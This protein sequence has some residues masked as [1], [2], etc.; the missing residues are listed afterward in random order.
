MTA[1]NGTRT[2]TATVSVVTGPQII[3]ISAT[4]NQTT[5]TSAALSVALTDD[6][7]ISDIACTWSVLDPK[8]GNVEFAI[9]GTTAAQT[10]TV[11][12][13]AIGSYQLQVTAFDPRGPQV[14][15]AV[16]VQVVS[17]PLNVAVT[18]ALVTLHTDEQATFTAAVRDQFG[19]LMTSP[20]TITWNTNGGTISSAGVFTA[21]ATLGNAFNVSATV[22]GKVGT[23]TAAVT[24]LPRIISVSASPTSVTG[25]STIL[26]VVASASPLNN[27]LRYHWSV[28]GGSYYGVAFSANDSSAASTTTATFSAAGTYTFTVV[29]TDKINQSVSGTVVVTVTQTATQLT[30]SPDYDSVVAHQLDYVRVTVAD[31][32]GASFY[33]LPTITWSTTGGQVNASQYFSSDTTGIFTVTAT[34][35]ALSNSRSITVVGQVL[36]YLE[37]NSSGS[38]IVAPG[39]T[40]PFTLIARD[41]TYYNVLAVPSD[42]IWSVSGGGTISQTGLFTAGNIGGTF[43]VSASTGGVSATSSVTVASVPTIT[44]RPTATPATVTTGT[45]TALS[46]Q[47]SD[48]GGSAGLTY[49]WSYSSG[50]AYV[51]F[52]SNYS[53]TANQTTATFRQAG[54][55]TISVQVT[56]GANLST[57][58]SVQVQVNAA[59]TSL[60]VTPTTIARP[61]S[62]MPVQFTAQGRD[63]FNKPT[64]LLGTLAWST[65]GG[66]T[67]INDGLFTPGLSSGG[68]YTITAA[69]ADNEVIKGTAQIRIANAPV[70]TQTPP[71][72]QT[73]TTNYRDLDAGA[74]DVSGSLPILYSWSQVSGPANGSSFYRYDYNGTSPGGSRAYFS[75][76][77]TYELNVTATN[78][79]GLSTTSPSFTVIV[80]AQ[81]TSI[82]VTPY[83]P[84]VAT[85]LTQQFQAAITDQFSQPFA[86]TVTWSLSSPTAGTISAT[87][88]F[89][90]GSTVGSYKVT[91]TSGTVSGQQFV[92]VV[93]PPSV[94]NIITPLSASPSTV[95]GTTTSLSVSASA[96]G[97]SY[98]GYTWSST[99]PAN[100]SFSG[101]N[102]PTTTATFTAAG[103][104]VITVT[105][106]NGGLIATSSVSVTVMQTPTKLTVSP[107]SFSVD[108]NTNTSFWAREED[109]FKQ[110]MTSPLTWTNSGIGSVNAQ[111]LYTAPATA[112][113][114][115]VSVTDP[116]NGLTA[117][118]QITVTNAAP[119]LGTLTVDED[120]LSTQSSTLTVQATDD[121]GASNLSYA[122]S[123]A[124]SAPGTVTF[125]V[126]GTTAAST[127]VATFS[128]PGSYPITVTVTDLQGK[129]ASKSMDLV[130]RPV[131]APT[132]TPASGTFVQTFLV[133]LSAA[134]H[135]AA[136]DSLWY[137]TAVAG[138]TPADPVPGTVGAI[139]YS[140]P[141]PISTACSVKAV[142]AHGDN[143]GS[144]MISEVASATYVM[145][146]AATG[147]LT[148]QTASSYLLP[149]GST[150]VSPLCVIVAA[151]TTKLRVDIQADGVS[152]PYV[153]ALGENLAYANVPLA[154]GRPTEIT[155]QVRDGAGHGKAT[156]QLITWGA[157]D[158]TGKQS[159]SDHLEIRIGDSVLITATTSNRWTLH[160]GVS[161]K[162]MQVSAGDRMPVTYQ[163]AGFY[164]VTAIAVDGSTL[165]SLHITVIDVPLPT[166]VIAAEVNFTRSQRLSVVPVGQLDQVV[167]VAADSSA[168]GVSMTS[169]TYE[170]VT[171]NLTPLKRGL[172]VLLARLGSATGPIIAWKE[173]D[174]FELK[175]IS[176]LGVLGD[177]KQGNTADLVSRAVIVMSP[178]IPGVSLKNPAST[179]AS[180]QAERPGQIFHDNGNAEWSRAT[181]FLCKIVKDQSSLTWATQSYQGDILVG[182]DPAIT[183]T[184]HRIKSEDIAFVG[185]ELAVWGNEDP[186]KAPFLLHTHDFTILP[187]DNS[188]RLLGGFTQRVSIKPSVTYALSP[189]NSALLPFIYSNMSTKDDGLVPPSGGVISGAEFIMGA[190]YGE[191][192][193]HDLS[194]T[195]KFSSNIYGFQDA[196]GERSAVCSLIG[197]AIVAMYPELRGAISWSGSIDSEEFYSRLIGANLATGWDIRVNGESLFSA[198][199]NDDH[200]FD[201]KLNESGLGIAEIV[202]TGRYGHGP[203]ICPELGANSFTNTMRY[204]FVNP[205]VYRF[206]NEFMVDVV[207]TGIALYEEIVVSGKGAAKK[208]PWMEPLPWNGFRDKNGTFIITDNEYGSADDTRWDDPYYYNPHRGTL[209][210]HRDHAVDMIQQDPNAT[211]N[212][213]GDA[214]DGTVFDQGQENRPYTPHFL[215]NDILDVTVTGTYSRTFRYTSFDYPVGP[216]ALSE[217]ALSVC[218]EHAVVVLSGSSTSNLFFTDTIA[219]YN[220]PVMGPDVQ[221]YYNSRDNFDR[222]L[223]RGW[224]TNYD[225]RFYDSHKAGVGQIL[226]DHNSALISFTG[227]T[228]AALPGAHPAMTKLTKS[229][230]VKSGKP[231]ADFKSGEESKL[232]RNDNRIYYFNAD[233]WLVRIKNV[234]NEELII[235]RNADGIAQNVR[236]SVGRS[237][238]LLSSEF[239]VGGGSGKIPLSTLFAGEKTWTFTY[240]TKRGS[241]TSMEVTNTA[242]NA[243][244]SS[245]AYSVVYDTD[246]DNVK[247]FEVTNMAGTATTIKYPVAD[248]PATTTDESDAWYHVTFPGSVTDDF[249]VA[250]TDYVHRRPDGGMRVKDGNKTFTAK[251]SSAEKIYYR[252]DSANAS[253][254]WWTTK[255]GGSPFYD[256]TTAKLQQQTTYDPLGNLIELIIGD[257]SSTTY[258]KSTYTYSDLTEFA[259]TVDS[260]STIKGANVLLESRQ[261]AVTGVAGVSTADLVTRMTYVTKAGKSFGRVA[262]VT[263]AIGGV[264]EY[265]YTNSGN[266]DTMTD[267]RGKIWTY[268]NHTAFGQPQTTTSPEGRQTTTTYLE[269][270]GLTA[271]VTTASGYVTS[272]EYDAQDRVTSV[273]SPGIATP[274]QIAYGPLGNVVKTT[275]VEN[276][277]FLSDFDALG[278]VTRQTQPGSA[279]IVT[280]YVAASGGGWEITTTQG[281]NYSKVITDAYGRVKEMK[282]PHALVNGSTALVDGV[283]KNTYD[284]VY[285]WLNSTTDERNYE[286]KFTRDILG[287]VIAVEFP[288]GG[289]S[290][291]TT[292]N[293]LGWVLSSTNPDGHTTTT[294]YTAAGQPAQITSPMGGTSQTQY[295]LGGN[296][297]AQQPAIGAATSFEYDD[298]GIQ[299]ATIDVFGQRT[300]R[301]IDDAAKTITVTSAQAPSARMITTLGPKGKPVTINN[302]LNTTT[303]SHYDDGSLN[304]VQ[305]NGRAVVTRQRD[306]AGRTTGVVTPMKLTSNPTAQVTAT[307]GFDATTGLPLTATNAQKLATTPAYAVT[308]EANAVSDNLMPGTPIANILKRDVA[309]NV[310]ESEDA[311]HVVTVSTYDENNRLKTRTIKGNAAATPPIPDITTT[312]NYTNGGLVSSVVHGATAATTAYEYNALG[313]VT[314]TTQ[315]GRTPQTAIYNVQGEV[316]QRSDGLTS[317]VYAYHPLTRQLFQTQ[318]SSGK[319]TAY[320]LDSFGRITDVKDNR[321]H[322]A[323]YVFDDFSRVTGI[324]HADGKTE[325]FTYHPTGEVETHTDRAGRVVQYAYDTQ[326][327]NLESKTYV[328]SGKVVTYAMDLPPAG[329][330]IQTS[331]FDGQTTTRTLDMRGRLRTLAMPGDAPLA[332]TYNAANQLE[333]KGSTTY[334]Y[335]TQGR[336]KTISVPG[337]G[338]ATLAYDGNGRV[339]TVTL[340]NGVERTFAYDGANALV[341]LDQQIGVAANQE[342]WSITRDG[343]GHVTQVSGPASLLMTFDYDG[344]GRL[345][346]ESR[347]SD[348]PLLTQYSYD[349]ADNRSFVVSFAAPATQTD[350]FSTTIGAE[351]GTSVGGTWTASG[352]VLNA[353]GSTATTSAALILATATNVSGP[354]V[355][356]TVKPAL[357]AASLNATSGAG[358]TVTASDGSIYRALWQ[359][360]PPASGQ[361]NPPVTTARI[362]IQ[363]VVSGVATTLNASDWANDPGTGATLSL[364]VWPDQRATA[365]ATTAT[366]MTRIDA[367]TPGIS[368][369]TTLNVALVAVTEGGA[370]ASATF[371]DLTWTTAT[372]RTTKHSV[373][374]AFNVLTSEDVVSTDPAQ[375]D[376]HRSFAYNDQGQML[377]RSL[378]F[379]ADAPVIESLYH[380]DELDRMTSSTVGASTTEYTYIGETWL[381]RTAIIG[382]NT[383]AWTYDGKNPLTQTITNGANQPVTTAYLR[384]GNTP[385]WESTAGAVQT[386]AHDPL[387]NISGLVGRVGTVNAYTRKFDYDAFGGVMREQFGQID[388]A[389][390]NPTLATIGGPA[391]AGFRGKGMWYDGG[392]TNLYKTQTRSYAPDLGRFTQVDPARAGTN[393]HAYAGGDP[394]NRHDPSGLKWLLY[395]TDDGYMPYWQPDPSDL[396]PMNS[397]TARAFTATDLFAAVQRLNEDPSLG[398][399]DMGSQDIRSSQP[400]Y[401]LSDGVLSPLITAG[402]PQLDPIRGFL[403]RDGIGSPKITYSD[404]ETIAG[405]YVDLESARRS[406]QYKWGTAAVTAPAVLIAAVLAA[407]EATTIA[408]IRTAPAIMARFYAN[409]AAIGV[410]A[411]GGVVLAAVRNPLEQGVTSVRH[412]VPNPNVGQSVLNGINPIF[413]RDSNRFGKA[414]YV[415]QEGDTAVL[416]VTSHGSSVS[417]VI[418]FDLQFSGQKVLNLADPQVAKAW[419]YTKAVIEDASYAGTKAIADRARAAGYNA[420]AFPSTKG[421]GI[422]YAIFDN[423]ST[424]LTPQA[425]A[426]VP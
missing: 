145:A 417:H 119:V 286:T 1:T 88:L 278:R 131:A 37:I 317:T 239:G 358:I 84:T 138:T 199:G 396:D 298:V 235:T 252:N 137:T 230:L 393:W 279:E 403:Y 418:R 328:S 276:R 227:N 291:S 189:S 385:L 193:I 248:N 269:P 266:L 171:L 56:N 369:I 394:V 71:T 340:P 274:T 280:T 253:V 129:T 29:A 300:E 337:Q 149:D 388:V 86:G 229:D 222:G 267:A 100:I 335:D 406:S 254:R 150:V 323:H 127:T 326:A 244:N 373:F 128:L 200:E 160:D 217:C 356:A 261:L 122:W 107:A 345:V 236:D 48:L 66:G 407:P 82:S 70:F 155:S 284:P 221:V 21:G 157:L 67:I 7:P 273:S 202:G 188:V 77:G 62:G 421:P 30:L 197:E 148:P 376:I 142:V 243:P 117:Q 247:K 44:V 54:L 167:W 316:L 380:Y 194:V 46:V 336:L 28:T 186:K 121:G 190:R 295:D 307:Q 6:I 231:I 271:S 289:G 140:G 97:A 19:A 412:A 68:P 419:G 263:D 333:S 41:Q 312:W 165:G 232:L 209:T 426:P 416:E 151:D 420:I 11:F 4:L 136:S 210:I 410:T 106:T 297:I 184:I 187:D 74:S 353:T 113:S 342:N 2:G 78:A 294:R 260:S 339:K 262:T 161:D 270:R 156:P 303:L 8:P 174:E 203:L 306:D 95:T 371:D 398:V 320:T 163:K 83:N 381:R 299:V 238:S 285:G 351:I 402:N 384:H 352:G 14:T 390:G 408:A 43:T 162:P 3:G 185:H 218:P 147:N 422:N 47:A 241:M 318:D 214:L 404:L 191:A 146:D 159:P 24:G 179:E 76:A 331:T 170:T 40:K 192:V 240:D 177:F 158:L 130:V 17:I 25:T 302:G 225:M 290:S 85:N 359:L 319:I 196:V 115:T 363:R 123:F 327:G 251:S 33:P 332:F 405:Q 296:V 60:A 34:T 423:F 92:A 372:S 175:Q 112:G 205:G 282:Q 10:T 349:G 125:S 152:V 102:S 348:L 94:P 183:A 181:S 365:K 309:G 154:I 272:Y 308:G 105:V 98:L 132:I 134:D 330:A 386:Y 219:T 61:P 250:G 275:D 206:G 168:L 397:G 341:G 22:S 139:R 12:F 208:T 305:P 5:G 16:T 377:S 38:Y 69:L 415:A 256:I 382:N 411:G 287:R 26:S 245:Y 176:A 311:V 401:N 425:V 264:T 355:Q 80:Q 91:A 329:G 49:Q 391:T 169:S 135:V 213:S 354:T 63:Q 334:G 108:L 96:A 55:Y 124:A 164:T 93:I 293:G 180:Y 424:I 65:T 346:Q 224:C 392:L 361:F 173:I 257:P 23:A 281:G 234:R 35:G 143:T 58:G 283:T 357:P 344:T 53:N 101:Y 111:G 59:L 216:P 73:I 182:D 13:H 362:I 314:K 324:T 52:S 133:T 72:T 413:L 79:L 233:G 36:T 81:A 343:Q 120:P 389:T 51:D 172:P 409:K 374:N 215:K 109:Q 153:Q 144:V 387:G 268:G 414:F 212:F 45:T 178:N 31:Q 39:A 315:S 27:P 87:G 99:G 242:G 366:S 110:A 292:Y 201:I 379:G 226:F 20:P 141:F 118:A 32:F 338:E 57:T 400:A 116:V 375:N 228:C 103:S 42:V 350:V 258:Q 204:T 211:P 313:Q 310:T 322:G 301:K 9:N 395:K 277:E 288:Y 195:A 249:V 104:Y 399:V 321:G 325:G 383:T 126:N 64:T 255:T 223:G 198:Y 368:S 220:T 367:D 18:P 114:A 50:P 347:A 166:V 370:N 237:R 360:A 364:T 207:G 304:T 75:K 90:T 246:T 378:A 259:P 15:S 265:T 89:T